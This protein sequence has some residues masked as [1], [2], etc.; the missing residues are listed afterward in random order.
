VLNRAF[1][2]SFTQRMMPIDVR[3]DEFAVPAAVSF[4][5]WADATF[6]T[7]EIRQ[8]VS[9]TPTLIA[10]LRPGIE[11]E[12][13]TAVIDVS[14]DGTGTTQCLA[15][16]RMDSPPARPGAG[17]HAVV[18]VNAII[19]KSLDEAGRNVDIGMPVPTSGLEHTDAVPGFAQPERQDTGGR[20]G[21]D[22]DK[23]ELIPIVRF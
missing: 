6:H 23:I 2:E 10:V 14:I 3:D 12:I 19:V 7:P 13:L 16:G 21:A 22:D 9:V 5:A 20:S 11:I 15:P 18:P 1:D 8:Y 4:I 17:L